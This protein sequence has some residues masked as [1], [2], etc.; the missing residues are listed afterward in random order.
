MV[1]WLVISSSFRR[2]AK[3]TIQMPNCRRPPW[4]NLISSFRISIFP[5]TLFPTPSLFTTLGWGVS[6]RPPPPTRSSEM[7]G[8]RMGGG[9]L[10]HLLALQTWQ[11]CREGR[12]R[13][14]QV[15]ECRIRQEGKRSST[16]ELKAR[17]ASS[18]PPPPT[19]SNTGCLSA[20][21][22]SPWGAF[23]MPFRNQA[24]LEASS[25]LSLYIRAH[26]S[27]IWEYGYKKYITS[28][29]SLSFSL[30]VSLSL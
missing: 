18:P 5:G 12:K 2:L 15:M 6:H 9:P 11:S 28:L 3:Q 26:Q 25:V 7:E 27:G 29:F 14:G 20:P 19:S 1:G 24:A 21:L 8:Q 22:A 17:R 13:M 4:Y 10:L 30:K 23:T 16:A